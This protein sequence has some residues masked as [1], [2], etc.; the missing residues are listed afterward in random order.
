MNPT[1]N[2]GARPPQTPT[3]GRPGWLMPGIWGGLAVVVTFL[4]VAVVGAAAFSSES[5]GTAAAMVAAFPVGACWSGLVAAVAV[6]LLKKDAPVLRLG[7]PVGCAVL[8]GGAL[9][10][11]V[12]LFFAVIFP[13]L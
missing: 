1:A 11:T 10:A 6:H 5:A 9:A 3:A 13:A 4:S 12:L 2:P 8:G 7:A